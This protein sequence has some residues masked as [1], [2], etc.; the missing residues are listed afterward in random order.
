MIGIIGQALHFPQGHKHRDCLS[1]LHFQHIHFSRNG[2]QKNAAN[3]KAGLIRNLSAIRSSVEFN[4]V[5]IMRSRKAVFFFGEI[6][7]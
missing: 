6:R 7:R 3:K 5:K 4:E 1:H 2:Y